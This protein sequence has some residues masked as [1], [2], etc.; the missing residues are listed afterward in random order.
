MLSAADDRAPITHDV[1]IR[2]RLT[3]W[4]SLVVVTV[5]LTGAIAVGVVE[6]RMAASGSTASCNGS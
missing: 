2:A 5:L 3:A 6:R 4:Y 1:S